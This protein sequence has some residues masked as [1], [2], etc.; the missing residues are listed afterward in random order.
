M[1]GEGLASLGEAC[2][3]PLTGASLPA[4]GRAGQVSGSTGQ[5]ARNMGSRGICREPY[6]AVPCAAGHP[7]EK[8]V[9]PG[10]AGHV[11]PQGAASAV[12]PGAGSGQCPARLPAWVSQGGRWGWSAKSPQTLPRAAPSPVGGW[13][14]SSWLLLWPPSP[15]PGSL[16]SQPREPRLTPAPPSAAAGCVPLGCPGAPWPSPLCSACTSPSSPPAVGTESAAPTGKCPAHCT[17][18]GARGGS[19][20]GSGP[21][22]RPSGWPRPTPVGPQAVPVSGWCGGRLGSLRLTGSHPHLRGVPCPVC[23]S[24]GPPPRLLLST[25]GW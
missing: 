10:D 23:S 14:S 12:A 18:P 17:P 25:S 19:A 15:V 1:A 6:R 8:A 5:S 2:W 22:P 7:E 21:R 3:D 20:P 11:E 16:G 4:G 9:P 24:R 13:G